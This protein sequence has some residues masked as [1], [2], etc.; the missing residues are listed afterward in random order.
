MNRA[1][2]S[3]FRQFGLR[4]PWGLAAAMR[5]AKVVSVSS[6]SYGGSQVTDRLMMVRP[7]RF[8]CNP[9][10]VGD[11]VFQQK[12]QTA[13]ADRIH[14]AALKEFTDYTGMLK[15]EGMDLT[16]MEDTL[17]LPDSVFPNNWI[18]FHSSGGEEGEEDSPTIVVYPMMSL[19][20]RKERNPNTIRMLA[21]KLGAE[22]K[23]YSS[24]E[25]EGK[26]LEGT[27]STVLDRVNKI[28][29]ACLS[30]R[31][32]PDVLNRFCAD[33]GYSIVPFRAHSKLE[34]GSLCPIYHTNVMLSVGTSFA[35]VCLESITDSMER[36]QVCESLENSGKE[37][38]A[39]S[40]QQ[41]LAFAGN[42]LQIRSRT[43]C[44]LLAMSTR[45]FQ[46]LNEGQLQVFR[47]HSCSVVHGN[48]DT[49]EKYSGGGARCMMAEIFPPIKS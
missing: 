22:V 8:G 43:G 28:T 48:L 4:G 12:Q 5:G 31:T 3:S 27:G 16:I 49:I 7:S 38:V 39:I 46:S 18:S 23:D 36:R 14:E 32:H 40:P 13:M 45:A 35:V 42:V 17:D 9:E 37:I 34:D 24:Y 47:K 26:F 44:D 1:M 15:R 11:N 21:E 29:Y 19:C 41:M 20:R 33:F 25:G 2:N 30:Q 6:S 10:T